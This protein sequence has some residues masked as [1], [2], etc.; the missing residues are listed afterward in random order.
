MR[1]YLLLVMS[2]V[3]V[4]SYCGG[5]SQINKKLGYKDD[6]LPEELV[7]WAIEQATGLE[8]DLTPDSPE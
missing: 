5:C 2:C 8:G 4:L 1:K 6:S 7:E 3:A